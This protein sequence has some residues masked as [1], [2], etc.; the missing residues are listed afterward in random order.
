MEPRQPIYQLHA[1]TR[2]ISRWLEWCHHAEGAYL[3]GNAFRAIAKRFF[4][5][6]VAA[7]FST[8]EG[9]A[10]AAKMIQ[11]GEYAKECLILC[12]NSWPI[13]HASHTDEHVGDPT[14]ESKILHAVTGREVDETGLYQTGE[15]VFNL[16]R[17]ILAREGHQGRQSDN[18]P[19]ADYTVPLMFSR[20]NYQCLVPGKAGEIISRK[21]EVVDREKFEKL[22]DEY[23]QL[24]GWDVVS[25]LQT[26]AKLKELGLPDI[27]ADL[28]SRQLL[29]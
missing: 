8:Y 24:R 1:I 4:G 28:E 20:G 22:K 6:E 3:S 16:Q 7:D 2:L 17:A 19:E 29:V 23:Y 25:G 27:A 12:D 21:G 5:S 15:R 18:L 10:L 9:K 13:M 26:K 14:I 11:D